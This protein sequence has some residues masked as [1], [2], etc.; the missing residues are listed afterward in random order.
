MIRRAEHTLKFATA[1][2]RQKL[3]EFFAEYARVVNAFIALYWN[4]D[5]LPGKANSSVYGQVDS[6]MMGKAR[7]CAVN[8]AIRILKSVRSRLTTT[9]GVCMLSVLIRRAIDCWLEHTEDKRD[10][11]PVGK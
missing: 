2:K 8:Q 1:A 6:W 4:T 3:D 11:K 7:K 5:A 9:K 10:G